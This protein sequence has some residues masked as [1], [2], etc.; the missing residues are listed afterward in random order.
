M[1]RMAWCGAA[2]A[3]AISIASSGGWPSVRAPKRSSESAR[4]AR[5]A[6][7]SRRDRSMRAVVAL[8]LWAGTGFGSGNVT[9]AR[10]RAVSAEGAAPAISGAAE[11]LARQHG[12]VVVLE[13]LGKALVAGSGGGEIAFLFGAPPQEIER[14]PGGGSE[15]DSCAGARGAGRRHPPGRAYRRGR[16]PS[17]GTGR[18]PGRRE[19]PG[20]PPDK[21]AGNRPAGSPTGSDWP[22]KPAPSSARAISDTA[23]P[24]AR[25]R[26][27][28][29]HR[30]PAGARTRPG[31]RGARHRP[32]IGRGRG[33]ANRSRPPW[34][35]L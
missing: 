35:C 20:T 31:H 9:A 11:A 33:R 26:T 17:N 13:S 4:S 3:P 29:R 1:M 18:R 6:V 25:R 15:R 19:N 14:G 10:N 16:L 7:R 23:G 34:R 24:D 32:P 27:S 30:R 2:A 21:A 8:A 22:R 28:S 5:P 12:V